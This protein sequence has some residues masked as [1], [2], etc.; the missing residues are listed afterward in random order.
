MPLACRAVALLG[1]LLLVFGLWGTRSA[2]G[3]RQFDEMA[4][5]L[6]VL[7]LALGAVLLLIASITYAYALR[8]R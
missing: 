7:A 8:R 6:P 1:G 4:G 2:A 3:R 5:I